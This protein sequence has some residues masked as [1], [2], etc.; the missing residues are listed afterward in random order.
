MEL[1]RS[2]GEV[3]AAQLAS[4]QNRRDQGQGGRIHHFGA[5]WSSVD[6]AV[7]AGLVTAV[8][9]VYL[10]GC[11]GSPLQRREGRCWPLGSCWGRGGM[12][13]QS[14]SI[15]ERHHPAAYP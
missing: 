12:E 15:C 2:T 10:Q 13:L 3:E 9:K 4:R 1:R 6:V 5:G 7:G 8:A 14:P 11:Q